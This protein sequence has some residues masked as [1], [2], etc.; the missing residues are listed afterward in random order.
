[1]LKTTISLQ[2]HFTFIPALFH[3]E[4]CTS[5]KP[6][7][8]SRSFW[9]IEQINHI[10]SIYTV[11]QVK[12]PTPKDKQINGEEG[13]L[14][15]IQILILQAIYWHRALDPLCVYQTGLGE[16]LPIEHKIQNAKM[17]EEELFLFC[18]LWISCL[19]HAPVNV[20]LRL[21]FHT[22]SS[23]SFLSQQ[24]NPVW[25]SNICWTSL[26]PPQPHPN[27]GNLH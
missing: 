18:F 24:L 17:K 26:V 13:D 5:L 3:Q 16:A 20:I 19:L 7:W 27:Y 25:I 6:R 4:T 8:S 10:F 9:D 23:I 22:G 14:I 1:M 11:T 15:E 21:S 12:G 2:L